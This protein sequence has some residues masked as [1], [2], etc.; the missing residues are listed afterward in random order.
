MESPGPIANVRSTGPEGSA[1]PVQRLPA[2]Q[3]QNIIDQ[4]GKIVLGA[5][6]LDEVLSLVAELAQQALPTARDVSVT[7]VDER[8]PRPGSSDAGRVKARTVAF[9]G[10][11]AV[12]LDERQYQA[13]FGPCLDAAASGATIVVDTAADLAT[14]HIYPEFSAAALHASVPQTLAVGLPLPNRSVGALNVYAAPGATFTTADVETVHQF[15]ALAAAAVANAA[16]F[17]DATVLAADMM[18]A[19]ASRATIEQAKGLLMERYG[20]SA[21]E[22]FRMLRHTSS[23]TNVKLR[24]VATTLVEERRP[25]S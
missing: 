14:E 11:L 1:G 4:L 7:L 9:R 6:T 3:R 16:L 18:A 8:H 22:A 21:E 5:Q 2:E 23:R 19:M 12:D 24:D 17:D 10:D 20:C 15:A 13:G 25:G